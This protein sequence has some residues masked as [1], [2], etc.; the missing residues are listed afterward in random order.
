MVCFPDTERFRTETRINDIE[1]ISEKVKIKFVGNLR[2]IKDKDVY[3][4]DVIYQYFYNGEFKEYEYTAIICQDVWM[5]EIKRFI[6]NF[7]IGKEKNS[8]VITHYTNANGDLATDCYIVK[9]SNMMR[10]F[11]ISDSFK[12]IGHAGFEKLF[13]RWVQK[14]VKFYCSNTKETRISQYGYSS[15]FGKVHVHT[16]K[17]KFHY[18][19][20]FEE[21]HNVKLLYDKEKLEKEE[22]ISNTNDIEHQNLIVDFNESQ[23]YVEFKEN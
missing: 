6:D 9:N 11:F 20:L 21:Y 22:N 2:N 12:N 4:S 17:Q 13:G 10:D 15:A 7:D 23:K 19:K 8:E 1:N 18:I 14:N 16:I 3:C 5:M